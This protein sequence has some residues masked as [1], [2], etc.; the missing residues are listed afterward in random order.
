MVKLPIILVFQLYMAYA[1]IP[2]HYVTFSYLM[3]ME[4]TESPSVPCPENRTLTHHAQQRA[5]P[6]AGR[7]GPHTVRGDLGYS[8]FNHYTD[9]LYKCFW[10]D[11]C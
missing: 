6:R 1:H 4:I 2:K 3:G 8:G 10:K 9:N 11:K 5:W 7:E